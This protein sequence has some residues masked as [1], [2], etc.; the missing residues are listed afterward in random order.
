MHAF[1]FLAMVAATLAASSS[2]TDAAYLPIPMGSSPTGSSRSRS[3]YLHHPTRPLPLM[4]AVKPMIPASRTVSSVCTRMAPG[5][6]RVACFSRGGMDG[7]WE[8]EEEDQQEDEYDDHDDDDDD[9]LFKYDAEMGTN[10]HTNTNTKGNNKSPDFFDYGR[11]YD[12]MARYADADANEGSNNKESRV[13]DT[14]ARQGGDTSSSN[15][16][17][18]TPASRM[19]REAM[20]RVERNA[21]TQ[22]W[23]SEPE[24]KTRQRQAPE[25]VF[26]D[27][28]FVASN[29]RTSPSLLGLGLKDRAMQLLEQ[30]MHLRVLEKE[31]NLQGRMGEAYQAR[32][33]AVNLKKEMHNQFPHYWVYDEGVEEFAFNMDAGNVEYAPGQV[34]GPVMASLR[35][36]TGQ[37][38]HLLDAHLGALF[39]SLSEH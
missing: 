20:D 31:G 3:T 36:K 32:E 4:H 19:I 6:T 25:K 29:I 23:F 8:E 13:W 1:M 9:L 24:D 28:A 39:V 22:P 18:E 26:K 27:S 17:E 38:I 10:T 15:N 21:V 2:T 33:D 11:E 12:S 7:N 30:I 35:R 37:I 16:H 14:S 5:P 34:E